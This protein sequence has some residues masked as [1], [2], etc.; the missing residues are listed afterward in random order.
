MLQMPKLNYNTLKFTM[1]FVQE[2]SQHEPQNRMSSYNC[3]VTIG[4]NIFRPEH[5]TGQNNGYYGIMVDMIEN[6]RTIF[7]GEEYL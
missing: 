6:W 2:V 3:S 5:E 7:D 1:A 4:P